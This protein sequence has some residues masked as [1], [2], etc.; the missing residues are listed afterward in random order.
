MLAGIGGGLIMATSAA[1]TQLIV[2]DEFRGRMSSVQLL[3]W[4]LMPVGTL[5]LAAIA[6]AAG[7]PFALTVFGSVGLALVV[8]A[9][10]GL[11]N[12]RRL[13]C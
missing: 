7:L 9:I 12:V 4:G 13:Q 2:P 5:P 1:I 10:L 8:I 3:I 6:S 11:P